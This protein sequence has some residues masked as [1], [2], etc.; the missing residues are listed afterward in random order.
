MSLETSDPALKE[1]VNSM[2]TWA[3]ADRVEAEYIS[4][5]ITNRN[6]CVRVD[7]EPFF[8]RLAGEETE[9]LGINRDNERSAVVAAAE[10]GM[11]PEVVAFLPEHGCLITEW[12]EGTPVPPEDLR[13]RTMLDRLVRSIK[14]FHSRSKIPGTFSP[15]RV[16]ELYRGSAESRGVEVP[17]VYWWLLER[18]RQVEEVL[19]QDPMSLRPCHNDLLNANFLLRDERVMIVDYEYAGMGDIFFDLGNLSVNNEFDEDTD[20]MLLE[21]YFDAA[22]PPRLARLKLM[23]LMSDFREAMWGVMQQALSSLDFDYVDYANKHFARCREHAE[24]DRYPMWLRDAA[25]K[26]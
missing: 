14:A 20:L 5:G 11:G 19:R 17:E 16:V 24:D 1:V 7:G 21:L 15:F 25:S 23:R 3:R 10:A 2:P 12:I 9:A 8:V 18:A 6:Y 13:Q 22:T 4:G 26:P